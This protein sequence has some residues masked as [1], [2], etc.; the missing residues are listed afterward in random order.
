MAQIAKLE[1]LWRENPEAKLED[2]D[3][4]SGEE[5]MQPI[6]LRYEDAYQ[7]QNIIGPLVKIEADYDKRI[8]E[9]QTE[10]DIIIRWDMGLNQ[11]RLA[12]FSMPKLESGEVRLAVWDELRLKFNGMMSNGMG[13]LK[14]MQA[15]GNGTYKGWEGVGSVIKT[16]NSKPW[17]LSVL[18]PDVSDEIC[19]ELRRSDGAPADCTHGFS[20][21]FVWKATSF[22]R[23]Q[24]AMKT[25]A[26]DEKSVSGYIVR[27]LVILLA[28]CPVS[29]AAGPRVG[30]AS[31]P[32][33]DAQAVFSPKSA[34][35]QPFSDGRGESRP[36]KAPQLDSRSTRYRQNGYIRV[37]R[38]PLGQNEP[39][40][41]PRLCAIQCCR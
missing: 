30:A 17:Q 29:Q 38:L 34:R 20:V 12:W 4:Q 23:M 36:A 13:A 14:G 24:M 19:L 35:T 27:L 31:S 11:K 40:S 5:E 41:G 3:A 37:H 28:N 10:N 33:T 9:S 18:T 21:D 39:R 1:D 6:L 26:I 2:A 8:K 15:L 16:P 25:F 32:N 7:Y 22:D